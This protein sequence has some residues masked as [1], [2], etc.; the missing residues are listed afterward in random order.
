MSE[1]KKP[2]RIERSRKYFKGKT[3]DELLEEISVLPCA[4]MVDDFLFGEPMHILN[5]SLIGWYGVANE[6][7]IFAYF[8][9]EEEAF[10]Y[11]LD[12]INRILNR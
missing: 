8:G 2:T 12:F 7:G 9:D 5:T 11:R 6:E 1:T 4:D 10:K 3:L